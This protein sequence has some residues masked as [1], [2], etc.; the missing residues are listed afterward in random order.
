MRSGCVG[1]GYLRLLQ[2]GGTMRL[3]YDTISRVLDSCKSAGEPTADGERDAAE[4]GQRPTP[5]PITLVHSSRTLPRDASLDAHD[6]TLRP[7][8]LARA[9]PLGFLPLSWLA[10]LHRAANVLL[11]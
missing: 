3:L 9:P 7:R 6:D 11:D 1:R 10:G 8:S 2:P 5:D 4:K